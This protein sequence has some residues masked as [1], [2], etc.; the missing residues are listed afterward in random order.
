MKHASANQKTAQRTLSPVDR[1]PS[2]G[3]NGLAIAPPAYGIDSVD[4]G[5][6]AT[7]ASR[8]TVTQRQA[9]G[10]DTGADTGA[11]SENKTGLPD[12]LKAG[13]ESLS[14][15]ALDNVRVHYNSSRP[16]QLQALAYTQGT[17]I[18]VAPGQERHL[19]HEA[20]HVVQQAQGRVKPTMQLKSGVSVNDD[21]GLEREAEVMGGRAAVVSHHTVSS[22]LSQGQAK[23][24]EAHTRRE[25]TS[26]YTED[27]GL[28]QRTTKT[29]IGTHTVQLSL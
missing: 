27:G 2:A 25:P 1:V 22:W 8:G 7:Q 13:I 23:W 29:G 26:G 15:V 20:W 6:T 12:N 21:G 5:L 11:R 17:D 4:Q 9:D 10:A 14:G 16:A 18:H 24:A 3:S 19:P 28:N